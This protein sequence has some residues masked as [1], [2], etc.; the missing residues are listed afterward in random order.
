M[1][2][3]FYRRTNRLGAPQALRRV[4]KAGEHLAGLW[5]LRG[6]LRTE[7]VDVIH[8]QWAVL[9]PVERTFY[10]RLQGDGIPVV[11]TAHDP[12]P[13][14]G[15]D[16]R[17]RSVAA[18]ARAFGRVIVHSEWGRRALVDRCGVADGPRPGHPPRGVR[19]SRRATP[20]ARAGR[21]SRPDGAAAGPDPP[22]Q[23]H[24]RPVG[25]LAA[26]ASRGARRRNL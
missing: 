11:F 13:N 5:D 15:G 2:E 8:V 23:G 25:G 22:L 9:R 12:I 6:R 20:G 14:V 3:L 21:P 18:T 4:A 19:V 16:R 17:R 10:R 1:R 26:S 24:R 7:G